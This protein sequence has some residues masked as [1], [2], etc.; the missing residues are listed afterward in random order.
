MGEANLPNMS[1]RPICRKGAGFA[2]QLWRYRLRTAQNYIHYLVIITS[3][4]NFVIHYLRYQLRSSQTPRLI[5]A[6]A[7]YGYSVL[8]IVVGGV[9]TRTKSYRV[10][11]VLITLLK[12]LPLRS[13]FM[14]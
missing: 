4:L 6:V 14:C 5:F 10:Y 12:R 8:L 13:A 11:T 3:V 2:R 7:R 9:L 1:E